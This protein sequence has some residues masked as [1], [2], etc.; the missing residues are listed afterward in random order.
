MK[1]QNRTSKWIKNKYS[2]S[3][4]ALAVVHISPD[5]VQE[6]I[7]GLNTRIKELGIVADDMDV[8]SAA[9]LTKSFEIYILTL[10]LNKTAI[11]NLGKLWSYVEDFGG[12]DVIVDVRKVIKSF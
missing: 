7:D 2:T 8:F 6:W 12:G 11:T 10:H 4:V 1:A 9:Y 3:G 5:D